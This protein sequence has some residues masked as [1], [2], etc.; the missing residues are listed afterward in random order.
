M[1]DVNFSNSTIENFNN[2]KLNKSQIQIQSQLEKERQREKQK[3]KRKNENENENENKNEYEKIMNPNE[4]SSFFDDILKNKE[5][6]KQMLNT[7]ILIYKDKNESNSQKIKEIKEE[8]RRMEIDFQLTENQL[9]LQFAKAHENVQKHE[10]NY[11]LLDKTNSH[12]KTLIMERE[13]EIRKLEEKLLFAEQDFH[14]KK[15]K[16]DCMNIRI[17]ESEFHI[18]NLEE[19]INNDIKPI[20]EEGDSDS[21]IEFKRKV[22]GGNKEG[23]YISFF[24]NCFSFLYIDLYF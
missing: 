18:K 17:E 2:D 16:L 23:K 3:Q 8:I 13:F 24:L 11:K 22:D 10:I 21:I 1:N 12:Y 15:I 4:M 14:N 7:N 20:I 6:I 9:K 19:K 5:M